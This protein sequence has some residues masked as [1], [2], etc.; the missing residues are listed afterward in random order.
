MKPLS[1]RLEPSLPQSK[2]RGNTM[3][4]V[5][6]AS[7]VRQGE[8]VDLGAQVRSTPVD[9]VDV[10]LKLFNDA[11]DAS[12]WRHKQDALATA[13]GLDKS[14]L[15]RMRSGEKP[16]AQKHVAALPDD[17]EVIFAKLHAESFGLIVVAPAT[18]THDAARA[19]ISGMFGLLAPQLPSHTHGQLKASLDNGSAGRRR[20]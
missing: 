6:N 8:A 11:I 20:V 18:N 17:V 10:L 1:S 4:T 12:E 14:Y 15:S 19:F 7:A 3:S 5:A 2:G 13:M 16:I 9:P